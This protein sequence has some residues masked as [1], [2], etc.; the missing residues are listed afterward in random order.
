MRFGEQRV[1]TIEAELNASKIDDT[2]QEF[3]QD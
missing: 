3:S 1:F 2:E